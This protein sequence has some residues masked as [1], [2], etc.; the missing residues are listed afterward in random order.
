MNGHVLLANTP[1]I[2]TYMRLVI[3]AVYQY[4]DK[5]GTDGERYAISILQL[6]MSMFERLHHN[7]EMKYTEVDYAAL[8]KNCGIMET[9][10]RFSEL[11]VLRDDNVD[12]D[13]LLQSDQ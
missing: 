5:L 2:T 13:Y 1:N 6:T 10:P 9:T 3:G 7:C 8:G 11:Y 12:R 4:Q